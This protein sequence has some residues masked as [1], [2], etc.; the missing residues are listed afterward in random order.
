MIIRNSKILVIL[1]FA[2]MH[3]S[4]D[5]SDDAIPYVSFADIVINVSLPAYNDLNTKGYMNISGGVKGII[6]Y[7]ASASTYY[8]IERNCSFSPNDACATVEVDIS[9]LYIKDACCGSTFTLI[10]EPTSP[11][12]TRQLRHYQTSQSSNILTITDQI[13][14]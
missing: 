14:N 11:P 13:A 4:P 9:G 6:L 8:A 7:K 5:L 12:A 10:G 3:C 2:L 1:F